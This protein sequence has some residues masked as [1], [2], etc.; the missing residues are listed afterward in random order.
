MT[1]FKNRNEKSSIRLYFGIIDDLTPFY[2]FLADQVREL[3]DTAAQRNKPLSGKAL[4]DGRR[5]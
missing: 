5:P 3:L 4:R 1:L 2:A